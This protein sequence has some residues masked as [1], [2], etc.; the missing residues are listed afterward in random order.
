MLLS[1]GFSAKKTSGFGVIDDNFRDQQ[2]R[3]QGVLAMVGV[4][5]PEVE[6]MTRSEPARQPVTR[7]PFGSCAEM[8]YQAERLAQALEE[9]SHE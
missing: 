1:Y 5:L 7:L 3:K 9:A 8:R 6:G 2:G 4:A